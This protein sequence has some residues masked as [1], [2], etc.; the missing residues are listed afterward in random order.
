MGTGRVHPKSLVFCLMIGFLAVPVAAC[1]RTTGQGASS[2][3]R[4]TDVPTG[5]LSETELEAAGYRRRCPDLQTISVR[6]LK[7]MMDGPTKPP[8]F[9]ARSRASYDGSLHHIPER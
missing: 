2:K 9:D 1:S 3:I 8:I 4:P 7:L 6:Q 5:A